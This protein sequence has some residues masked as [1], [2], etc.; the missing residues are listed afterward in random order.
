MMSFEI[1]LSLEEL[2]KRTNKSYL[3]TK[4][5]LKADAKE[6]LDLDDSDKKTLRNLVK[7]AFVL[8]DVWSR[9]SFS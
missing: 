4:K 3:N 7:A 9:N 5:M 2:K 6:Y 8:E 1:G